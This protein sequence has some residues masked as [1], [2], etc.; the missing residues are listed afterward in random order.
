MFSDAKYSSSQIFA[1]LSNFLFSN[2]SLTSDKNTPNIFYFLNVLFIKF[3]T[4]LFLCKWIFHRF[5][6][7]MYQTFFIPRVFFINE[8][9]I[10]PIKFSIDL[11]KCIK[12][13]PL[14]K[15]LYS[16]PFPSLKFLKR[17][18]F[19]ILS[20]PISLP[21]LFHSLSPLSQ[22]SRFFH[23]PGE[24]QGERDLPPRTKKGNFTPLSFD[25]G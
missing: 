15:F 5:S 20:S 6:K 8:F 19:I 3:S 24:S 10:F 16:F 22:L 14:L 7:S 21:I 2:L 4:F 11:Q 23:V 9:F 13:F 17:R 25:G 18:I 12:H 1:N